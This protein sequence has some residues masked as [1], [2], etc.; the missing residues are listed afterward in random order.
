MY[1][2]VILLHSRDAQQKS[3]V[4]AALRTEDHVT[5]LL[6]RATRRRTLTQ[7]SFDK[8]TPGKTT[9]SKEEF[10]KT[11][12]TALYKLSAVASILAIGFRH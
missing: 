6:Q 4:F 5:E 7:V 10:V 2:A 1:S 12:I 9:Y 11:N 8:L 3:S